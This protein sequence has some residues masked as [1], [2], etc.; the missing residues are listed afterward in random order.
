MKIEELEPEFIRLVSKDAWMCISDTILSDKVSGIKFKCPRCFKESG[1]L[2]GVHYITLWRPH[3]SPKAFSN[4]DRYE[5]SGK[6]IHFLTLS[7]PV[8][9]NK[10]GSTFIVEGGEITF[11]EDQAI[12]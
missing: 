7:A 9:H 6:Y 3:V 4:R 8:H 1:T 11:L 2:Q 12:S 10:C 5:F